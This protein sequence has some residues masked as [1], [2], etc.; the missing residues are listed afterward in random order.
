[1]GVSTCVDS[2]IWVNIPTS[3]I[4]LAE[5]GMLNQSIIDYQL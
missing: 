4:Q 1:M 2:P 5:V 3:T